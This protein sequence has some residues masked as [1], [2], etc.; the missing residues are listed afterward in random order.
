MPGTDPAATPGCHHGARPAVARPTLA[1]RPRASRRTTVAA[2]HPRGPR[3]RR[4][5]SGPELSSGHWSTRPRD[6]SRR[7]DLRPARPNSGGA[8]PGRD[9]TEDVVGAGVW[10]GQF[11]AA[12]AHRWL[13]D[14]LGGVRRDQCAALQRRL[15][16][17]QCPRVCRAVGADST[18]VRAG[19]A[20]GIPRGL[21][22]AHRPAEACRSGDRTG[23]RTVARR[24]GGAFD[25]SASPGPGGHYE[26][27]EAE[28]QPCPA[29]CTLAQIR[30]NRLLA[31]GQIC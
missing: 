13:G 31:Y 5:G 29:Q 10:H 28:Q 27:L 12:G 14:D 30:G 20:D 3:F 26:V 18:P 16:A 21:R 24:G 7:I 17:G 11:R 4:V 23:R 9:A 8:P 19:G 1:S 25:E 6:G 15:H 22:H 2:P